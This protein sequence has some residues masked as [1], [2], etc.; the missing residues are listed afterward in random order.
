M[1]VYDEAARVWQR[2]RGELATAMT[3]TAAGNDTWR[4]F[5]AGQQRFFK[6]LC[7]SM[8][9]PAVVR[10]AKE[11]LAQGQCV[12]IGLQSTGACTPPR[13]VCPDADTVAMSLPILADAVSMCA[14]HV[15]CPCCR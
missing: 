13:P 2:V 8:K 14:V 4:T 6:L 15:E 5:W 11:A 7:V 9:V 12:V 3:L 1:I 10:T